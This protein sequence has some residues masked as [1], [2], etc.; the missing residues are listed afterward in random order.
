MANYTIREFTGAIDAW[1]KAAGD[2]LED[3]VRYD[4]RGY[5]TATL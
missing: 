2:A 5:P 3:V 4:V 1:C